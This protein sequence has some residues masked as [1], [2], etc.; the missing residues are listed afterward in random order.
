MQCS[1]PQLN[2]MLLQNIASMNY[3]LTTYDDPTIQ[4]LVELLAVLKIVSTP[5]LERRRNLRLQGKI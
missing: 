1:Q 2:P 4:L 3:E 5:V